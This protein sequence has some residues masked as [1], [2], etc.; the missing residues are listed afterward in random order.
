[1]TLLG[2]VINIENLPVPFRLFTQNHL[3]FSVIG[4]LEVETLGPTNR[5]RDRASRDQISNEVLFDSLISDALPYYKR[6]VDT[7]FIVVPTVG[8]KIILSRKH[9]CF[10]MSRSQLLGPGVIQPR[11]S[12]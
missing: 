8:V 5:S 3:S 6:V 2:V 7:H 12:T 1:M 9:E 10:H 11:C 4:G